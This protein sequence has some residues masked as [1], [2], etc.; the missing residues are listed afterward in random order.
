LSGSQIISQMAC[1]LEKDIVQKNV[2]FFHFIYKLSETV[3]ILRRF[4]QDIIK[5]AAMS[6]CKIPAILITLP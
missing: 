2:C 3:P 4:E 1:F 6:S 5:T